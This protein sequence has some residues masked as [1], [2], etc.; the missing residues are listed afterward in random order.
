MKPADLKKLR[1]VLFKAAQISSAV[2][3]KYFRKN[4]KIEKKADNTIVTPADRKLEERLRHHLKKNFSDHR[5]CGEEFEDEGPKDSD[6]KWWIDPI[7]GTL[8]FSRGH[9]YWGLVLGLEY[10]GKMIAGLLHQPAVDQCI[11]AIKGLGCYEGRK[12]LRVSSCTQLANSSFM[13]GGLKEISPRHKKSLALLISKARDHRG[14]GDIFG[15]VQVLTGRAE[16][17][18]DFKVAPHDISAVK[19]C[20]EE[21]GGKFTNLSGKSSI[22]EGSAVSSNKK[23]HASVLQ[24]FLPPKRRQA[25]IAR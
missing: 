2:S 13:Y 7:D 20:I 1:P 25:L 6:Y 9:P 5:I 3:L 10:K 22:Y 11:H 19:I 24:A 8:S 15:H 21:A 18:L 16:F 17:M 4:L 14:W 23:L 12:K